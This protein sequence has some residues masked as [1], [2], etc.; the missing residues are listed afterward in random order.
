MYLMTPYG[1]HQ[2]L[3]KIY[4][5][6]VDEL[7]D[8]DLANVV[9]PNVPQSVQDSIGNRVIEAFEMKENANVIESETIGILEGKL[10]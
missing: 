8:I 4:G 6:V 1:Q 5:A 2:L 9:I 7:T 10:E 3:S